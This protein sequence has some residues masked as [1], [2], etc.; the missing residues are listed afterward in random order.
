MIPSNVFRLSL[1]FGLC[2]CALQPA[3]G[4]T[5]GRHFMQQVSPTLS[6]AR[7]GTPLP[8]GTYTV[9]TGG[10]FP[11][12]DSAFSRLSGGGIL[13]AVTLSLTDTVYVAQAANKGAFAL[14]GP[15]SGAGPSA[16]ITIRPADNKSVTIR[17]NGESTI[18]FRNVS[19]LTFD[20]ISIQGNTRL[21]V[22]ALVDT[23]GKRWNDGVDFLGDCDFDV[24]QNMTVRSDDLRDL[25][26][27]LALW[28]DSL[29]SPDSCIVSGVSF[30]S[31]AT[32]I[33]NAGWGTNYSPRPKGNVIRNNH[34]G[35]PTD[36]LIAVGIQDEGAD[37]TIVEN[38]HVENLRLTVSWPDGPYQFAINSYYGRS[39][40]IRNN[41]VNNLRAPVSSSL[42][43]GI[44]AS[45]S[46]N[47]RGS[48]VWIYNNM[49]YDL[50]A[51]T[52]SPAAIELA[53]IRAWEQDYVYVDNNTVHLTGVPEGSP[54]I[55]SAAM[56][57]EGTVATPTLRSNILVNT[58]NDPGSVA[59]RIDLAR[60]W[61]SDYNDLYAG[62]SGNGYVGQSS[63]GFY[64]S[65]S[66]W[67]ALGSDQK[68]VS[69]LPAFRDLPYLHI[70]STQASSK[71]IDGH[72]TPIAGILYD[73]D[74]QLRDA[75]TPDI[76]ADEFKL[77]TG[78]YPGGEE[79][80]PQVFA[81]LQNFPNPFNPTTSI[82]YQIPSAGFVT[83]G[84]YDLLGREVATLVNERKTAGAYTVKFDASG[85][86]SGVYFYR[87]RADRSVQTM[88]MLIL[89]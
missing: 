13:G 11:T 25:Q 21:N 20:G 56:W 22:H 42:R 77:L 63:L 86:A 10:Y 84:V 15:I 87:L 66:D 2:M 49:V 53:G 40:I 3:D 27:S 12:L 83:L 73:F 52:A 48:F 29:G 82:D 79:G 4:Q 89:K 23:V 85:L 18:L 19:Y 45:G 60:N 64:K 5:S 58:R 54:A 75:S 38:N 37:G 76:G 44:L 8:A 55:I 14:I 51:G 88:K 74:G 67:Q 41:I 46:G 9:G 36:S 68:S 1:V 69:V 16:R 32:G 50:R 61:G 28:A 57:I 78:V 80:I 30:T 47:Q 24:I 17:G 31:G 26:S 71:S 39:P 43:M 70:D 7:A 35:S 81:L 33:Y 62:S 34:I 72:G 65:L 6:L 59:L